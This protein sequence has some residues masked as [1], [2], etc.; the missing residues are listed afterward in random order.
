MLEGVCG[1]IITTD[2]GSQEVRTYEAGGSFGLHRD[3]YCR[4]VQR[5]HRKK[6]EKSRLSVKSANVQVLDEGVDDEA[7]VLL[8]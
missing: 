4:T 2:C 1:V 5:L 6:L 3:D 7:V 8:L